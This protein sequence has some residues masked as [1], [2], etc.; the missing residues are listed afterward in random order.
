MNRCKFFTCILI[1]FFSQSIFALA[2][3]HI[4]VIRCAEAKHNVEGTFNADPRQI[5]YRVS[6]LTTRGKQQA[7]AAAERLAM[8]GFD[9]RN[10]TAVYVSTLPRA[11]QTAR[12]MSDYGIFS[13]DKI[14]SDTRLNNALV[15]SLE[16]KP[17]A[18]LKQDPWH[19]SQETTQKYEL[20]SNR[21]VR[22]RML[23]LYDDI[24]KKHPKGHVL[25]I[26]HGMPAMELLQEIVQVE[27]RLKPSDAYILPLIARSSVGRSVS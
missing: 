18:D 7:S 21:Q 16:S 19:F 27:V 8:H 12:V 20:E 22:N 2:E 23:A 14:Y 10:I 6:N 9:N 11:M 17:Q 15:G 4:I 5:N 3:R 25:V 24:E 26:G 1:I 13:A